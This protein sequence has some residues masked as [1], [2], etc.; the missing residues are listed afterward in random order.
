VRDHPV[1]SYI[2]SGEFLVSGSPEQCGDPALFTIKQRSP[3]TDAGEPFCFAH[4]VELSQCWLDDRRSEYI[5]LPIVSD[6][7]RRDA[8]LAQEW[9]PEKWEA[10]PEVDE[11]ACTICGEHIVESQ[12]A[13]MNDPE[14]QLNGGLV[15][16]QCGIEAGWEVS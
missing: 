11:F 6:E 4:A 7:E 8:L 10:L 13:E 9:A 3:T 15:H 12:R 16:A 5:V 2:I 14:D 1:C